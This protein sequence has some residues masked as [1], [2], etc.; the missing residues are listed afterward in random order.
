[1]AQD[2]LING[3]VYPD[4]PSVEFNTPSGDT[5]RFSEGSGSGSVNSVNGQTG[6]VV[7]S[8]EDLENDSGYVAVQTTDEDEGKVL[9][10]K[11]GKIVLA[12]PSFKQSLSDN[13]HDPSTDVPNVYLNQ[14]NGSEIAYN[15]WS[16]SDFIEIDPNL[17]YF[18]SFTNAYT[19]V[20][21]KDKNFLYSNPPATGTFRDTAKYMRVSESTANVKN[22]KLQYQTLTISF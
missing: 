11:D 1:M 4:V 3:V 22:W 15:G 17:Y 10:V 2:I 12:T 19:C 16:A 7:L 8:T 18:M 13:L 20:Y 14:S 9:C 21:D 5:V 6:D